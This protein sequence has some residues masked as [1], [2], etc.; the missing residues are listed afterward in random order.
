MESAWRCGALFM[1]T[2]AGAGGTGVEA[3]GGAGG[4]EPGIGVEEGDGGG[5]AD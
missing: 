4:E 1:V 5:L 3:S 2:G